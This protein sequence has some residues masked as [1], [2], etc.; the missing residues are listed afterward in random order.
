M[1]KITIL[2]VILA[3]ITS[4]ACDKEKLV[5]TTISGTLI[6][7]GT[8][9]PILL[10]IELTN[11]RVVLYH[12]TSGG[13]LIGGGPNWDEI[14][15]VNVDNNANFSF[16]LDLI[17]G[18]EYYLGYFGAD[19]SKYFN[20]TSWY[21]LTFYPVLPGSSHANLKVFVLAKSYVRHRLI[22]TNPNLNNLDLLV[23]NEW[24][25]S[26]VGP[27]DSIMPWIFETYSGYEKQP[28]GSGQR[29]EVSAKLTRNGIT[30]DTI[31]PYN[32]P[33]FDTTIVEI[34]Y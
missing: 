17:E 2:I 34:R 13:E 3:L 21:N 30:K 22:N 9:D 1:K 18:D 28:G 7:N 20:N 15:S 8:N 33:P 23:I 6:T 25:L 10:S 14:A 24:G 29:H 16:N 19:E 12:S 32:A 26:F 5:G 31:I 4:Y 27:T 11:P